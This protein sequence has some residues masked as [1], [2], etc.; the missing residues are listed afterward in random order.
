MLE[1]D[2]IEDINFSSNSRTIWCVAHHESLP[3]Q[4]SEKLIKQLITLECNP[5]KYIFHDDMNTDLLPCLLK[6]TFCDDYE[7]AAFDIYEG[8]LC[9]AI[10]KEARLM[11]EQA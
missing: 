4:I 6:W 2:L 9:H 11:N 10:Y 7:D 1:R 3:K 8:D 5:K